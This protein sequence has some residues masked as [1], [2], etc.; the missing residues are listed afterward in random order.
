MEQKQYADMTTIMQ[1]C[2]IFSDQ[3]YRCL[4]HA[5]LIKQGYVL[6]IFVGDDFFDNKK[7]TATIHLD[8]SINKVGYDN[9]L[10]DCMIQVKQDEKGWRVCHDP[11]A[12]AGNVPPVIVEVE[13]KAKATDMGRKTEGADK[14]LPPDGLWISNRD[15][16][17]PV[18]GGM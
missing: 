9:W 10:K 18:D 16:D 12:E 5:G 2:R 7:E 17:C 3:M 4:D 8:Q 13:R 14:P 11:K 15:Y 1:F 6:R